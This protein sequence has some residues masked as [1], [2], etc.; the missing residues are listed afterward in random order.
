MQGGGKH[1]AAKPEHAPSEAANGSAAPD[2]GG[3]GASKDGKAEKEKPRER[4]K[5]KKKYKVNEELLQAF[6]YFD[7]NC[8]YWSSH[9]CMV[10]L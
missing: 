2:K 7:R 3:G 1:E 5:P 9:K 10:I 6:R 8:E 4:E